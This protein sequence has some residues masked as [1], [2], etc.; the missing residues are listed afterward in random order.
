M[1]KVYLIT[2]C[3][4][5][6][7]KVVFMVANYEG[8]TFGAR[9]VWEVV[10]HGLT[11]DLSTAIYII[12]IPFL[13]LIVSVWRMPKGIWTVFKIYYGIISFAMMLAFT[14]D[15]SLYPFWGF[16]LDASCLQGGIWQ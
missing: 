15:T 10:R 12:S 6:I 1:T 16:K 11:L 9:D 2:V 8:H 14:A 3:I 5:V 13:L 4:F 7:A